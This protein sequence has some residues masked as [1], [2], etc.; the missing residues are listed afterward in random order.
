MKTPRKKYKSV[1]TMELK[2]T[3]LEIT[4]S[5]K[6]SQDHKENNKHKENRGSRFWQQKL[7]LY[8]KRIAR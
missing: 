1:I 5:Q 8:K 3:W 7:Y 6:L 4:E 2:D